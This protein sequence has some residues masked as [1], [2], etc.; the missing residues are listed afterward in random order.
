M[1]D[2]RSRPAKELL[3]T[4]SS[5]DRRQNLDENVESGEEIKSPLRQQFGWDLGWLPALPHVLTASMANF[6]F[7]YHIGV[8]NGPIEVIAKELGF[9][10]NP[11]LEG[12]VV[13]IFIVGAFIGCI[14]SSSLSEKLGCRRTLQINAIPLIIGA[15]LSAQAHSLDEMLWGRFIVGLGI[16]VN[17][18]LVP[19]YI[20]EIS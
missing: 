18:V 5:E 9:D 4:R 2:Y 7:G 12:L 17:T 6:L 10:G 13:S 15:L 3:L 8:M 19:I 20:S 1:P 14:S 16:G 11:F